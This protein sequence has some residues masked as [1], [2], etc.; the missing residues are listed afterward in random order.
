MLLHLFV[1]IVTVCRAVLCLCSLCYCLQSCPVLH[2]HW[3]VHIV[4]SFRAALCWAPVAFV[5][6]SCRAVLCSTLQLSPLIAPLLHFPHCSNYHSALPSL[7]YASSLTSVGAS[8]C[9]VGWVDSIRH[10]VLSVHI[11]SWDRILSFPA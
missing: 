10:E 4:K 3:F 6:T 9:K 5:V 1:H 11:V 8:V 2:S 7:T